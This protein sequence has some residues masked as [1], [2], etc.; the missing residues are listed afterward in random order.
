MKR[1]RS[2]FGSTKEQMRAADKASAD[3]TVERDAT[4]AGDLLAMKA[5]LADLA[6]KARLD[7]LEATAVLLELAILEVAS[8]ND[9]R[10]TTGTPR[11]KDK[12]IHDEVLEPFDVTSFL[13]KLLSPGSQ[14]RHERITHSTGEQTEG[15]LPDDF[16]IRAA[17]LALIRKA[18][19]NWPSDRRTLAANNIVQGVAAADKGISVE[20]V[21]RQAGVL[22]NL[23]GSGP[24]TEISDEL[25]A[26]IVEI[27]PSLTKAER[28]EIKTAARAVYNPPIRKLSTKEIAAIKRRADSR[29]WSGRPTHRYS[30][31]E[32]V[33]EN[34]GQWIPG[35]LQHHLKFDESSLYEAF[36]KRVSRERLPGWL[37]VPTEAEAE[38]RNATSPL[39]R[40]KILAVRRLNRDHMRRVRSLRR[41]GPSPKA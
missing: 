34:Y 25:D 21:F 10:A 24:Q 22:T 17:A 38:I 14:G 11:Q 36:A 16:D 4:I 35:L 29:P 33:R 2:T 23:R 13:A 41:R 7:G 18:H 32:W 12:P 8:E 40:A 27:A 26:A 19:P 20:G 39:E 15:F 3:S 37:D 30:A 9:P 5:F 31:F 28:N 6:H 1:H